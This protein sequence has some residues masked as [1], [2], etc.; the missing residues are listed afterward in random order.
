MGYLNM[1]IIHEKFCISD[2]ALGKNGFIFSRNGP[3]TINRQNYKNQ[4]KSEFWLHL[5][6][7]KNHK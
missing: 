5:N 2:I 6:L 7:N 1:V 3:H 4:T